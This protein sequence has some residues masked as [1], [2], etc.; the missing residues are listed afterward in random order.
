MINVPR[1]W[2]VIIIGPPG[3][4]KG[5]QAEMLAEDFALFN[6]ETSKVIEEKIKTG[7]ANNPIIKQEKENF[8]SGK[9]IT[10]EVVV[11]WIS[12]KI[13]GLASGG[14][15]IGFSGLPPTFYQG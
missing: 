9:L 2:V 7:D 5:T 6:F 12:E 8:E 10:P 4:G 11:G 1:R 14:V 3:A 13:R 15:G